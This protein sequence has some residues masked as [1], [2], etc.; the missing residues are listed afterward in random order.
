MASAFTGYAFFQQQSPDAQAICV[1]ENG[2]VGRFI[3]KD[4]VC[5]TSEDPLSVCVNQQNGQLYTAPSG[6]GCNV[7]DISVAGFPLVD[8]GPG[9]AGPRGTA[10][11]EGPPGNDGAP[12][13]PGPQGPPGND[14][15]PGPQGP[16]G[17]NGAPGPAG[18]V[19]PA[20][21]PGPVGQQ[22][23]PGQPGPA[24]PIGPAGNDGN[25][26]ARGPQGPPGT[27]DPTSIYTQTSTNI[28]FPAPTNDVNST[29]ANCLDNNDV[30]IS[31]STRVRY[32]TD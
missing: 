5:A 30:A 26:G 19:G 22:G 12:G 27:F 10:G 3:G 32:F 13:P 20:G 25:D 23:P 7:G 14:G 21:Q 18:P 15:A 11:S 31:G 2:I 29:T 8:A 9:A 1:D 17:S 6:T 24:G 16:A 4:Q 28:S